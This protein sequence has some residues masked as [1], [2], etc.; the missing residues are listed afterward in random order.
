MATAYAA[1]DR[2]LAVAA[3]QVRSLLAPVTT[4][5]TAIEMA[6]DLGLVLDGWQAD[7]LAST[8]RY[9]LMLA[10]RQSGKSM[11]AALLALHQAVSCPGSLTL[12]ISPS[13][14]QS[15]LLLTTVRRFHAV[16]PDVPPPRFE[17]K[18]SIDLANGSQ[19]VALPSEERTIRGF[20]NVALLIEDEAAIV[21]D[22]VYESCR[23]MLAVSGGRVVLLST[24]RG[25]RGH[26]FEE[27]TNGGPE[28][29]RATVS[30]FDIPRIDPAWLLA[31]RDR[32]GS[33]WFD[34]EFGVQFLDDSTQFFA[35]DLVLGAVNPD[36]PAFGLPRFGGD[37]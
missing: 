2:R 25:R 15:K 16:L 27:Y 11:T 10:S 7:V 1:L 30:A 20:S 8:D 5:R 33:F 3:Y 37:V 9:L 24:P 34:Q 22:A 31:E 29:H 23:P 14:R 13:E 32:I 19:V 36:R 21:D 28:W 18:L 4:P 17:G 6:T 26:F 35:T 12:I